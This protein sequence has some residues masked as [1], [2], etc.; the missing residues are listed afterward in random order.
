MK[1]RYNYSNTICRWCEK[2]VWKGDG[3][4]HSFDGGFT[5]C[6]A[7]DVI[8]DENLKTGQQKKKYI[9]S[10]PQLRDEFV[11]DTE[12][13]KGGE[14]VKDVRR[15]VKTVEMINSSGDVVTVHLKWSSNKVAAASNRSWY[16]DIGGKPVTPRKTEGLPTEFWLDDKGNAP[17]IVRTWANN[18]LKYYGYKIKP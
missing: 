3:V 12:D 7:C 15:I 8:R 13:K 1:K 14:E 6:I 4:Y 17:L 2:H 10:Q 5:L 11:L 9:N 16:L 18:L